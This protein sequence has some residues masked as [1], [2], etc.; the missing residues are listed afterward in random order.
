M[1]VEEEKTNCK[2]R[3][4]VKNV[5]MKVFRSVKPDDD[6]DPID[7]ANWEDIKIDDPKGTN[8]FPT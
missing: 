4:G 1:L 5:K 6:L 3:F 8:G 2:L 7:I